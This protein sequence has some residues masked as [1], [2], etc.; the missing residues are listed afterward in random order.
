MADITLYQAVD[1]THIDAWD[2]Y[3]AAYDE[4]HIQFTNG[5]RTQDYFGH[6]QY[7]ASGLAGGTLTGSTAYI[8]GSTLYAVTNASVPAVQMADRVDNFDG[9]GALQLVM[10]G[11]DNIV[12]SAGNDVLYGYTGNDAFNGG[13]GLDTV[14][15]DG[16]R[17]NYS[18][19]AAGQGY[20][21]AATGK[22]D[23]LIDVERVSFGDGSVLALDVAAGQNA[24]SAY[25]LYQAAFDRTPDTAGL[26]FWTEALD[27]GATLG[28][29]AQGFVDSAEFK[30]LNP[31]SDPASLVNAYYQ[32]VLH[33]GPDADGANFWVSAMN[34]GMS[35][36][37]VL[38][39][40][41]ESAENLANTSA[42]LDG[43][44]WLG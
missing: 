12:G 26:K 28:Q 22:Q 35:A 19:S 17:G 1:M 14:H 4:G 37:T 39:A 29:V 25:R 6:F 5:V 7:D 18:V 34:D 42:A 20:V 13:G 30:Q 27:H 36:A 43:G 32:N 23:T 24:G 9:D 38:T 16:A 2:G 3:L 41:S 31:G 15:Y 10:A 33:R 21:V 40:F 8:N 11:N 44:L